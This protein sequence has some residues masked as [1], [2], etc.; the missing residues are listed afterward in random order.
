M[1][2]GR[3]LGIRAGGRGTGARPD[4]RRPEASPGDGELVERLTER[5]WEVLRHIVSGLRNKEIA[6]ALGITETTVKF[7]VAHLFEKL[8]VSSRA[9]LVSRSLRLGIVEPVQLGLRQ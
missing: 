8:R 6:R 2:P 9:E 1:T 4:D 7:H 3:A 5:E